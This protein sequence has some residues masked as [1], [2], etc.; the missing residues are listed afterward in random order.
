MISV[1]DPTPYQHLVHIHVQ[2]S[3]TPLRFKISA[4]GEAHVLALILIH[5]FARIVVRFLGRP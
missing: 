5:V 1:S 2:S 4:I 3:F